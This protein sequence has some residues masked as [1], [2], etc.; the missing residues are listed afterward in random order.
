MFLILFGDALD[1][2]LLSTVGDKVSQGIDITYIYCDI[3]GDREAGDLSL[4]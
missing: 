2:T 3:D 4:Y 1:C